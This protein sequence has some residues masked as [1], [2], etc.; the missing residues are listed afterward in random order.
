LQI[1]GGLAN[2]DSEK[3]QAMADKLEFQ[4]QP[5]PVLPMQLDYV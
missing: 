3:A 5:V 4:F 2:S 1:P